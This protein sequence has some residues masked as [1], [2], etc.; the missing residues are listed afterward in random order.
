MSDIVEPMAKQSLSGHPRSAQEAADDGHRRDPPMGTVEIRHGSG[1]CV[2][3]HED[4]LL[5]AAPDHAGMVTKKLRLDLVRIRMPLDVQSVTDAV[6]HG[7]AHQLIEMRRPVD[8]ASHNFAISGV[9]HTSNMGFH[10]QIALACGS[11]SGCRGDSST[12]SIL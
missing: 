7:T 3:L 9:L 1:V 11:G 6:R 8:V 4:A 5:L 2:R 12:R 10:Q